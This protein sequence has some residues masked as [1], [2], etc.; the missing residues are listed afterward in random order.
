MK[1]I[2]RSD[3]P[4]RLKGIKTDDM[5]SVRD[6]LKEK[7]SDTPSRLKGI[8]TLL[9][10]CNDMGRKGFRHTFPFEGN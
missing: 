9:S 3:T 1:Y 10:A 8:K 7:C 2:S 5:E 6:R 4:S